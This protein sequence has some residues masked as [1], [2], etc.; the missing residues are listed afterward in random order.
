MS[1]FEGRPFTLGAPTGKPVL[2]YFW[3]SWC[4]PC[5][6]ALPKFEASL[7]IFEAAGV[8]FLSVA[9]DERTAV[10]RVLSQSPVSFPVLVSDGALV[11]PLL[12][13]GSRD[14]MVPYSVVLDE[15]GVLI[16]QI[17][18]EVNISQVLS[19]IAS[20]GETKL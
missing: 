2:V 12:S 14:G 19:N 16:L 13:L 4:S 10:R 3:A 20:R 18:G 5:L 15:K 17:V 8:A 7:G 6:R 11:D 1:D 9:Q